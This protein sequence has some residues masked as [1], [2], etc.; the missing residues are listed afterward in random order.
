MSTVETKELTAN[1]PAQFT[2]TSIGR[3]VLMAITGLL[4]SAFVVVHLVGNLQIFIGQAQLNA[5]A[6]TLQSLGVIKWLFRLGLLLFVGIHIW[7]GVITWWQNKQSRPVGYVKEDT[8]QATLASRTM[9]YTGL[10][11]VSFVV[12]HL[13]HFTLIVTNP[14]YATLPPDAAG[15]FDA[16]KMVVLG[17]RNPI[18]AG[19]YI[20]AMFLLAFHLT[21]SFSS[22]F[23]TL[24][25]N[26]NRYIDKLKFYGSL[27]AWLIFLAYISIPVAVLV[28]IVKL[29]GGGA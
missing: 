1:V 26:N 28:G 6:H 9:I 7:E 19:V 5:Y 10:V 23:Q 12:Y 27:V 13:L 4:L 11:I 3:K 22:M 29:P 18:I 16:Y 15:N 20:V 8:I 14:Q 17:F 21:H 24:G 25:L 2:T